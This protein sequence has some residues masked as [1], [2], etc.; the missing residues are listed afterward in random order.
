MLNAA[1]SMRRAATTEP[2]PLVDGL[3]SLSNNGVRVRRGELVMIAGIPNAGKSAFALWWIA[4][5]NLPTLYFSADNSAH[6]TVTRLLSWRTQIP[7][8]DIVADLDDADTGEAVQEAFLKDL[9]DSPLEFCFDGSLTLGDITAELSAYVE[10]Y[11]EWPEV[12]VVDNLINVEGTDD[13][14][15]MNGILSEL[16]YCARMTGA[17]VFVLH[18]M[19][20]AGDDPR[21]APDP[22][23]PPPMRKV[24]GKVNHYP[25]LILSVAADS[26]QG[27]FRIAVPKNRNAKNDPGSVSPYLLWVDFPKCTFYAENP[28]WTP[29]DVLE[30]M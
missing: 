26:L 21:K 30:Y 19:S 9:A 7:R 2:L 4:S 29:H 13:H 12:I 27:L 10:M 24:Q 6:Q 11:D 28:R 25:D 8:D 15:G 3:R 14:Q 5:L 23:M 20:E 1:R 22:T 18:H 17:T 16:H